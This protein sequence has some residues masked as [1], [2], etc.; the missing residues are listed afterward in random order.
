[1]P[2]KRTL[3]TQEFDEAADLAEILLS[4]V[5]DYSGHVVYVQSADGAVFSRAILQE[6]KLT[7]GS[8]AYNIILTEK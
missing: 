2:N 8:R 7:D 4:V 3:E 1:M 5:T 6:E